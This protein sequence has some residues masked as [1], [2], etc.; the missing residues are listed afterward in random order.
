MKTEI[1]RTL[2][3]A[4][5]LLVLLAALSTGCGGGGPAEEES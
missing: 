2:R 5:V 1:P 4:S 3:N